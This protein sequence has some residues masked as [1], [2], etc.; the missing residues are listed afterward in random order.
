MYQF[1]PCPA[2]DWDLERRLEPMTKRLSVYEPY[3]DTNDLA[4]FRGVLQALFWDSSTTGSDALFEYYIEAR[5]DQHTWFLI[6]FLGS[7]GP[8]IAGRFHDPDIAAVTEALRRLILTTPPADIDCYYLFDEYNE[9]QHYVCQDGVCSC[10]Y[11]DA[12]YGP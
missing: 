1:T 11:T 2:P 9:I 12:W 3:A 6:A 7:S 10:T 8:M 5:D 4:L